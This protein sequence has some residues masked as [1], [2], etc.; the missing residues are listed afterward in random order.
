MRLHQAARV[1]RS[2]SGGVPSSKGARGVVVLREREGKGSRP[3]TDGR[4]RACVLAARRCSALFCLGDGGGACIDPGCWGLLAAC[5][6]LLG[7]LCRAP[8]TRLRSRKQIQNITAAWSVARPNEWQMSA[9]SAL[10]RLMAITRAEYRRSQT[11]LHPA[12]DMPEDS[13][14]GSPIRRATHSMPAAPA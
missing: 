1:R 2:L 8:T 3:G 9:P 14:L 10:L 7:R 6:W 5:A 4:D 13:T 11:D 12:R